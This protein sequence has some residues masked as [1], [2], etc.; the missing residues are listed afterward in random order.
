M[1]VTVMHLFSFPQ[2]ADA[3]KESAGYWQHLCYEQHI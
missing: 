3:Q 1:C 2:K